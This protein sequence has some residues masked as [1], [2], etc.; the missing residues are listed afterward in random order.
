VESLAMYS[1]V[2]LRGALVHSIRSKWATP[3][4]ST[5]TCTVHSHSA[6]T[7]NCLQWLAHCICWVN[8]QKKFLAL[9]KHC[10]SW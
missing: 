1:S 2:S 9:W 10:S 3:R 7:C 5:C 8:Q 4:Q 6:V